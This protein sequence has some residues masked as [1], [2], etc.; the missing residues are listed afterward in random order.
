MISSIFHG[1]AL[2]T[3][4]GECN[5]HLGSM[6]EMINLADNLYV[7]KL[8][9]ASSRNHRPLAWH[10]DFFFLHRLE[11]RIIYFLLVTYDITRPDSY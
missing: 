3:S 1:L 10:I 5:L 9:R 8:E 4:V 6:L 2:Y 7:R 11:Q